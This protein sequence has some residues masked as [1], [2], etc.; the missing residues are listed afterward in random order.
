MA[1]VAIRYGVNYKVG[2]LGTPVKE[3]NAF[4]ISWSVPNQATNG[5][6]NRR[7]EWIDMWVHFETRADDSLYRRGVGTSDP[8]IERHKA[9]PNI[10]AKMK[11][12]C[13]VWWR[14]YGN[15]W[16]GGSQ[17]FN[18]QLYY[19]FTKTYLRRVFV[20]VHCG[21]NKGGQGPRARSGAFVLRPPR[22]PSMESP[23]INSSTQ[24]IS[25]KMTINGGTD[26]YEKYDTRYCVTCQDNYSSTYKKE[27]IISPGGT[28]RT[29]T[30]TGDITQSVNMPDALV[31][32]PNHWMVIKF[33]AYSRGL[34]GDSG[35]TVK[36]HVFA[37]PAQ[38][39]IRSITA[40][41]INAQGVISINISTNHSWARPVDEV[42][43]ERLVTESTVT[44]A[45]VAAGMSGWTQACGNSKD[46]YNCRGFSETVADSGI[47]MYDGS[48]RT[49]GHRLWYRIRTKHDEFEMVSVPAQASVL[50]KEPYSASHDKVTINSVTTG[51][52]GSSVK[53]RLVWPKSS[54]DESDGSEVSWSDASDAW[55]S[56]QPPSTYQV[57]AKTWDSANNRYYT[58][59]VIK[60]LYE[61]TKYYIR[62]RR[63]GSDASG[64]SVFGPYSATSTITPTSTP[65]NVQ[66]I[67]PSYAVR[68][69]DIRFTWTFDGSEQK[70][71]NLYKV[72]DGK[73]IIV[74]NGSDSLGQTTLPAS[75]VP[76]GNSA[77][78]KVGVSSG[79]GWAYSGNQTI[80]IVYPPSLA[81]SA[82]ST[83]Q[84]QPLSFT[85]ATDAYDV[86][87]IAKVYSLGAVT[88]YPDKEYVQLEGDVVWSEKLNP[89]WVTSDGGET[90][91]ATVNL[92]G[93]VD[94]IDLTQYVVHL[95]AVDN[96]TNLSAN[97]IVEA[98]TVNYTHKASPPSV[99]SMAFGSP[100][101]K[102]TQ[103]Y[104]V[105][106]PDAVSTDVCDIYRVTPDKKYLIAKDVPF[107]SVVTDRFAPYS[108]TAVLLYRLVT[109][110]VDGSIAWRDV[111][112]NVTGYQ[113]RFDWGKGR[114]VE[115]PYNI[116]LTDKFEKDF[117]ARAH[118]DGGVGGYWN[119][120][121]KRTVS[122]STQ[123][124][125]LSDPGQIA[126][127]KELAGYAGPVFVRT[128]DGSAYSADVQVESLSN[129][130][131]SLVMD[132]Q[133]KATEI[134]LVDDHMVARNDIKTMQ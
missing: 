74:A 58:D 123:L 112:Y 86:S 16:T 134:D 12:Q 76:A 70:K 57:T 121:V 30:I 83:L 8:C 56:T 28:W 87:V 119:P 25:C 133:F 129:N 118:L 54:D 26:A 23:V 1:N 64:N 18:R 50:Y 4:R 100:D 81:L 65:E 46:D 82:L 34:M 88:D 21:N 131:N 71:W 22:N 35:T 45:A 107:G 43:I 96:I 36:E 67:V 6:N 52:D 33:K 114:Y 40:S 99:V 39:S 53:V 42:T 15:N 113:I 105:A 95:T 85:L 106:P 61:G 120:S 103:I 59:L 126:L 97:P 101:T 98:F 77:V 79:G 20:D 115:L 29:S 60:N 38:A 13:Q 9:S 62:A 94:F 108:K 125:R 111:Q 5:R 92:P 124:V 122:L 32:S 48:G 10:V 47:G 104:P 31:S 37:Y 2:S 68:G 14:D 90:Y 19:P 109:R 102:M 128:P 132:A 127:V 78:F 117:E 3:G 24:T 44:S 84:A 69:K 130:Y 7:S 80:K 110:T 66:L 73:S 91:T 11:P 27:K 17:A 116:T 75:R 72:V 89:N 51:S 93:E 55:N 63:Y 41:A 49:T